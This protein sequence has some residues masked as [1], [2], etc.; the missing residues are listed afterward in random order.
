MVVFDAT[1]LLAF[2]QSDCPPPRHPETNEPID[3]FRERIDYLIQRLD[4]DKE[5]IIIPSPA[6]SEILVRAAS[7]GP[8]YLDRINSASV[9]RPASFD[10]RGAVEVAEMTRNALAS[11]GGK[12]N[13]LNGTYAKIKYDRQI[14]AIAKVEGAKTVY[15]DD[16]NI[17]KFAGRHGITVIRIA[18]LPLPPEVAQTSLLLE[19]SSIET[20]DDEA[21]D[22]T[23]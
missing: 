18:D 22:Q 4:K 20:H 17:Y 11:E 7:A 1:I 10:E 8:E 5:K 19:E 23:E 16:K 15:S 14:V 3:S 2:L 12:Y 9:F 13:G 6:L 21:T